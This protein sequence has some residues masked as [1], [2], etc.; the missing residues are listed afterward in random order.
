[1]V[2]KPVE[3]FHKAG[4]ITLAMRQDK[5]ERAMSDRHNMC[6]YYLRGFCGS[7]LDMTFY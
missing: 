7:V 1:M 4:N 5:S 2:T 3:L 6:F